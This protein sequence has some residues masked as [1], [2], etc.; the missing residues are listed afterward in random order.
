MK[1]TI[2][3]LIGIFILAALVWKLWTSE[4]LKIA[5]NKPIYFYDGRHKLSGT[6]KSV[7]FD[8]KGELWVR[9]KASGKFVR[10]I[11]NSGI[12]FCD[13]QNLSFTSSRTGNRRMMKIRPMMSND[14]GNDYK[15]SLWVNN[16]NK[17]MLYF[18]QRNYSN[19]NLISYYK[20]FAYGRGGLFFVNPETGKHIAHENFSTVYVP[21][22][23]EEKY[24]GPSNWLWAAAANRKFVEESVAGKI[25]APP[26]KRTSPG[27]SGQIAFD[28]K[29]MYFYTGQTS[30]W[31]RIKIDDNW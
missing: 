13:E 11:P 25:T 5:W 17:Y 4:Q 10:I 16:T 21:E 1:K 19:D 3:F 8:L 31:I 26:E 27:N 20:D 23:T 6:E 15:N 18:E 12:E 2:I 7:I 14:A 29:Y 9:D 24:A 30:G 28:D 22:P